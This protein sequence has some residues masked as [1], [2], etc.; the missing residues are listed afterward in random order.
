MSSDGEDKLCFLVCWNDKQSGLQ[1]DFH[2]YFYPGSSSVEMFDIKTRKVFLKKTETDKISRGDLYLGNTILLYA[3]SLKVM[4]YGDEVTRD[5]CSQTTEN[6]L[7]LVK[8]EA[9]G[10]LGQILSRIRLEGIRLAR[11]RMVH[12][13]RHQ[14]ERFYSRYRLDTLFEDL[15]KNPLS[16]QPSEYNNHQTLCSC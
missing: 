5:R 2:L 11:A 10:E 4:D 8:P 7:G 6:T 15:G 16:S 14:A 9:V 12:L 13:T 3:R 1:R